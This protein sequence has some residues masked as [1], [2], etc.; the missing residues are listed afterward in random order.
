MLV[1]ELRGGV[2]VVIAA[3]IGPANDHD[4]QRVIVYT[5]VV[6]WWFEEVG[7]LLHPG[8]SLVVRCI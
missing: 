7:V 6:D 5:K 4:C 3:S 2:D 1:K 8:A